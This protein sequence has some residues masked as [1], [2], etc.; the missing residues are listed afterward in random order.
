MLQKRIATITLLSIGVYGNVALRCDKNLGSLDI[1]GLGVSPSSVQWNY[2]ED[3][4]LMSFFEVVPVPD[5]PVPQL[6]TFKPHLSDNFTADIYSEPIG[7]RA[8]C[9]HW[10]PGHFLPWNVGPLGS[11]HKG[12]DENTFAHGIWC[13]NLE[14]PQTTS[15]KA[16]FQKV[17]CNRN[18]DIKFA[19]MPKKNSRRTWKWTE[20]ASFVDKS[21][22]DFINSSF[23][24]LC[25]VYGTN[26]KCISQVKARILE[27]S[28]LNDLNDWMGDVLCSGNFKMIQNCQFFLNLLSTKNQKSSTSLADDMLPTNLT[29]LS[30]IPFKNPQVLFISAASVRVDGSTRLLCY[31]CDQSFVSTKR[32]VSPLVAHRIVDATL[33]SN[34]RSF[35]RIWKLQND[36]ERLVQRHGAFRD[37]AS[38]STQD[39]FVRIKEPSLPLPIGS[40]RFGVKATWRHDFASWGWTHLEEFV[41]RHVHLDFWKSMY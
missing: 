32:R 40:R 26:G 37:L 4:F 36:Y 38:L 31:C 11:I 41:G 1:L 7:S 9:C 35:F 2:E 20:V 21:S 25:W 15:C 24:A 29:Q 3:G 8:F 5:L 23:M 27:N 14:L 13:W 34:G 22:A 17:V 28:W 19:V 12:L 30:R 18:L 16:G 33:I 6:T 39:S 10:R